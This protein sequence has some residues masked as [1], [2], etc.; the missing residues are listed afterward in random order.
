[1]DIFDVIKGRRSIRKYKNKMP[2]DEEIK[3]CI[4]AACFAPS[5]H[6]SQPW[7]FVV[8][9][10][11]EKIEKLSRT[12]KWSEFLKNAPVVITVLAEEEKSPNHWLEDCSCAIMLLMLEAHSL[13]LG[14]C[15]NAVYNPG[16]KER[17]EYVRNVLKI[18]S[19]YRVVANIG[20]G[21]PNEKP[22]IKKVKSF[23]E[24][25]KL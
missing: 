1:M 7:K 3:K 16:T 17:E 6:N 21:Y 14:S 13:G 22:G 10:E 11:R 18:P 25:T 24:A 2:S 9:K 23:E 4:E 8:V 12:Q 20:I 19:K 5:A 15:W